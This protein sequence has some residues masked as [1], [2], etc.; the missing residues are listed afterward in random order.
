MNVEG[1]DGKSKGVENLSRSNSK[2]PRLPIFAD[3]AEKQPAPGDKW[4]PVITDGRE[5]LGGS[6]YWLG[7]VEYSIPIIDR[8]RVAFFYDIGMVYEDPYEF[9]FSD[10]ADNW[11]IGLSLPCRCSGRCGSTTASPSTHPGLRW[12][13]WAVSLWGRLHPRFLT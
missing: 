1:A 11:G 10:Y 6:S 9:E 5:T 13:E 4:T 12:R 7:S 2:V 8:L 3:T